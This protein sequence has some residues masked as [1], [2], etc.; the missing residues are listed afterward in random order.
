MRSCKA[1]RLLRI[2]FSIGGQL[3]R[4][5]KAG[6]LL[7]IYF[8]ILVTASRIFL[9]STIHFPPLYPTGTVSSKL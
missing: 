1:G 6:R 2:Y 7:R 9:K 5:C 8:S 3:L 4:S